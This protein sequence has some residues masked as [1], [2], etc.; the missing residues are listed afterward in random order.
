MRTRLPTSIRRTDRRG[1]TLM[2]VMVVIAIAI[3][4]IGVAVPAM[5]SLLDLQLRRQARDLV[6]MYQKLHDEA[7][8]QNVSFRVGYD[9]DNNTYLIEGGE[10]GALIFDNADDREEWEE[11]VRDKL[12]T[13]SEDERKAWK[14]ARKPFEA[15]Q[16]RIKEDFEIP[17]GVMIGGIYTP[18]YGKFMKPTAL[19]GDL[20]DEL[21]QDGDI[22]GK[23]RVWTYIFPNGFSEHTVIWVVD[24]DDPTNGY[25]VEIEPMSGGIHLHGELIDWEGSYDFVPQEGPELSL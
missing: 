6:M 13:M 22:I 11:Q 21:N 1:M 18:Q 7:I 8:L 25:T 16:E 19:G 20:A 10:P 14:A 3:V 12:G 17:N 2:E 23:Q 9:M 24:A 5:A 15:L 4:L